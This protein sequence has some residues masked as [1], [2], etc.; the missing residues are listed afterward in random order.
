MMSAFPA[1]GHKGGQVHVPYSRPSISAHEIKAAAAVLRSGQLTAGPTVANFEQQFANYVGAR[2]A[3]ATSSGFAALFLALKAWG[4]GPGDHVLVPT[5]TYAATANA[6][7]ATGA[8]PVLVDVNERGQIDLRGGA[9]THKLNGRVKAV[10]PVHYG[11]EVAEGV[12]EFATNKGLLVI[13]D[14]AHALGS[15]DDAGRIGHRSTAAF[16]FQATKAI[17]TAGEGGML[18]TYDDSVAEQARLL[19]WQGIVGRPQRPTWDYT[20]EQA[21]YKLTMTEMQAAVGQAQLDRLD[22]FL[23]CRTHIADRYLGDARIREAALHGDRPSSWH[24]FVVR[25]RDRESFIERLADEGVATSVHWKPLHEHPRYRRRP[26]L[27]TD[28]LRVYGFDPWDDIVSLPIYPTMTNEQVEHV[29]RVTSEALSIDS[30]HPNHPL[31]E[32]AEDG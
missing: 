5:L 18:V 11:G 13:E 28:P 3:I 26:S 31:N 25:V 32:G 21:G 8:E 6:V 4:I 15:W 23:R 27:A 24:L 22:D 16:S 9:T 12:N 14:A 17:T 2:H 10:V 19:R 1:D 29:I 20:I 30:G 7:V